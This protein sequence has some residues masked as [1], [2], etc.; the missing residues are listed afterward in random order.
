MIPEHTVKNT[1][2]LEESRHIE[3]SLWDGPGC[4][5][6]TI[7]MV[8]GGQSI[9]IE[10]TRKVRPFNQERDQYIQEEFDQAF[11]KICQ[12]FKLGCQ[13]PAIEGRFHNALVNVWAEIDARSLAD[14]PSG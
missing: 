5:T 8:D 14:L 10:I 7:K 6:V 13:A 11:D 1:V 12:Y 2:I 4:V 9:P 3:V